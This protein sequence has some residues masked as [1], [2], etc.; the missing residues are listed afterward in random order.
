MQYRSPALT[1]DATFLN[2]EVVSV[3]HDDPSGNPIA[4]LKLV[5]TNQ[6]GA[7]MASGKADVM[8]PKP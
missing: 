1:G 3:A 4:T 2:G 6:A 8:L 5:M 7:V